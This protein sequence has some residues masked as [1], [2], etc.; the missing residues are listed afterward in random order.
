MDRQAQIDLLRELRGLSEA[1]SFFLGDAVE[2][3]PVERYSSVQR[4]VLERDLIFR[5]MPLIA[6]HSSELAEPGCFLTLT[7]AGL[8]VLLTRGRDGAVNAFINVCRHRGA[9]LVDDA[10]GCKSTFSCPYHGWTWDN[11]GELRGVPHEPAGFPG[12]D[13]K[14]FGLRRLPA[15]ERLGLIWVIADP[16]ASAEFDPVITPLKADFEWLDMAGLVIART[17]RIAPDANW[18]L[19]AEGGIEA[20]HFRVTHKHTIGPHFVDNLSSFQMLGPHMRSI[21]PRVSIAALEAGHEADWEIRDHA[22]ILYT[23]LPADQFLLMQ[24]HVAWIHAEP[25]SESRTELRVSTLVPRDEMT[26][27]KAEHWAR[28][29]AITMATLGEDFA[30]NEAVQS[31]LGSGANTALTFGRFEGALHRFNAEIEA[32]LDGAGAG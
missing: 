15:T 6:A 21:L 4:F 26:E 32:R 20:Y 3:S 11:A 8:P 5:T 28:N 12:L 30:L 18:K 1:R 22:N 17:D 10:G 24:D 13:R 27:G 31:G 25:A 9:R 7:L 23:L 19:L 16:D 29:H 14:T 2:K